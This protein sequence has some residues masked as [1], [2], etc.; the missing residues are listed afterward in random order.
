MDQKSRLNLSINANV[1]VNDS[2]SYCKHT[3]I[4]YAC[5]DNGRVVQLPSKRWDILYVNLILPL[6]C[7]IFPSTGTD[8]LTVVH[9][10]LCWGVCASQNRST[11]LVIPR[12]AGRRTLVLHFPLLVHFAGE[13][14]PLL[15]WKLIYYGMFAQECDKERYF[16]ADYLSTAKSSTAVLVGN[17]I[18]AI[19]A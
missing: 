13:Q 10:Q 2:I 3:R 17:G 15:H 5:I 18:V 9:T 1:K 12:S 16:P 11:W 6:D 4:P 8:N 7:S 14:S 19:L